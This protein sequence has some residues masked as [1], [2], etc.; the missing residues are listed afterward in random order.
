MATANGFSA[1][2]WDLELTWILHAPFPR[3]IGRAAVWSRQK[4]G[5]NLSCGFGQVPKEKAVPSLSSTLICGDY[6]STECPNLR[7]LRSSCKLAA[8]AFHWNDFLRHSHLCI[9][10]SAWPNIKAIERVVTLYFIGNDDKDKSLQ[11]FNIVH[12]PHYILC[13]QMTPLIK[14]DGSK[15]LCSHNQNFI[16]GR[17]RLTK[18]PSPSLF[19][20]MSGFPHPNTPFLVIIPG[21]WNWAQVDA[22]TAT[23][24]CC[25]H[26]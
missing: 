13:C 16:A 21:C 8:S 23:A 17:Y 19:P 25:L 22:P 24:Q 1:G 7:Q 4:W 3:K 11:G 12:K 10:C 6:H 2:H 18:F 9:T 15:R 20:E 26:R 14:N 5:S